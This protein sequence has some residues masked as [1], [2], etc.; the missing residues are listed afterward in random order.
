MKIRDDMDKKALACK[1][2]MDVSFIPDNMYVP[3]YK[4]SA[5]R[6]FN[7]Q[8]KVIHKIKYKKYLNKLRM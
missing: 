8:I 2:I 3:I 6:R 1:Y 7:C 4:Y 5:G